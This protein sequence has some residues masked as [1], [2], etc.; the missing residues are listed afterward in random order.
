MSVNLMLQK[1]VGSLT[2]ICIRYATDKIAFRK[3]SV[4]L[5][6]SSFKISDIS[7][8]VFEYFG[9]LSARVNFLKIVLLKAW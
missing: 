3:K 7:C 4:I 9:E 5:R 1:G 2:C 6:V 8:S